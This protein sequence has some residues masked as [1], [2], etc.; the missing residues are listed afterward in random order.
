MKEDWTPVKLDVAVEMPDILNLNFLRGFGLQPTEEL[1]PETVGAA[2]PPLV[3]DPVI[4]NQLTDMGFPAEACERALYFTENRGLEAATNWLME[5]IA[6][7]DFADPFVP[8]GIDVKPSNKSF[9][10][11][12]PINKFNDIHIYFHLFNLR[13]R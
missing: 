2:P 6:D 4:L 8:P 11:N 3:Y 7:S 1:L 12:F 9:S 5:H 10:S 13:K